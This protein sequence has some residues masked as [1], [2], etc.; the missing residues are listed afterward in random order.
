[1]VNDL[2]HRES[3]RPRLGLE[4][5]VMDNDKSK[6][7][8]TEEGLELANGCPDLGESHIESGSPARSRT[9]NDIK[10][11]DRKVEQAT[12]LRKGLRPHGPRRDGRCRGRAVIIALA[13]RVSRRLGRH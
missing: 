1:V 6:N 13:A 11:A 2:N 7:D 12:K 9:S 10:E 3:P 8:A 5:F 4:R